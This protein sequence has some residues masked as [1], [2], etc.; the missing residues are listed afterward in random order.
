MIENTPNLESHLKEAAEKGQIPEQPIDKGTQQL[1]DQE[2]DIQEFEEAT[3]YIGQLLAKKE[4]LEKQIPSQG[5]YGESSP[6][7]NILNS[8]I[9]AVDDELVDARRDASAIQARISQRTSGISQTIEAAQQQA[10]E[11]LESK[12]RQ[13]ADVS[14]Q[15]KNETAQPPVGNPEEEKLRRFEDSKNNPAISSFTKRIQNS[16]GGATSFTDFL[17]KK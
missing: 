10:T 15:P 5:L 13:D 17:K 3:N 1:G 2:K 12:D 6:E 4:G 14:E 9:Q 8:Q 16:S 7:M 11:L